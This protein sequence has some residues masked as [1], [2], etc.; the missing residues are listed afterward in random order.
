MSLT[1]PSLLKKSIFRSVR[2]SLTAGS[3]DVGLRWAR[4]S[5]RLLKLKC[6]MFGG[7]LRLCTARRA[8]SLRDTAKVLARASQWK[9]ERMN[10]TLE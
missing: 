10:L 2:G 1:L 7:I 8:D 6:G 3:N 5:L 4:R 9:L